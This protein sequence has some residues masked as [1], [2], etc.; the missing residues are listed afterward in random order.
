MRN[1][2]TELDDRGRP[3]H[4]MGAGKRGRKQPI[5]REYAQLWK[6]DKIDKRLWAQFAS[7]AAPGRDGPESAQNAADF[8]DLMYMQ[9]MLREQGELEQ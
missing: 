6:D 3:V 4:R 8:A 7:G 5:E 2:A 9:M 1:E